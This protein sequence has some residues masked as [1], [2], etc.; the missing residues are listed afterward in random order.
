MLASTAE[1]GGQAILAAAGNQGMQQ[2]AEAVMAGQ[3]ALG[4]PGIDQPASGDAAE[5]RIYFCQPAKDGK[6]RDRK[7]VV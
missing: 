3:G 2:T 4:Q 6:G 7:S 5:I 1:P